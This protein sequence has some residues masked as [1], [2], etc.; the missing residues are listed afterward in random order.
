[1]QHEGFTVWFTGMSGAGKSTLARLLAKKLS[2]VHARVEVLDGD[3]VRQTLCKDLDYGEQDRN[4]NVRRIGFVCELLSRNNVIAIVAAI[5]PYRTARAEVRSR[6]SRFVEVYVECPLSVLVQRDPKGLYQR[7]IRGE[8][9]NF[10][11]ISAPYEPPLMPELTV[12]SD[13]ETPESA[14]DKIWHEIIR[15]GLISCNQ[16]ALKYERIQPIEPRVAGVDACIPSVKWS[17]R[18]VPT[19]GSVWTN[20]K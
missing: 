11:G 9:T 16:P 1:M 4:E 5:S 7:A 2:V 8:I 13:R 17:A 6:I 3:V 10:T 20:S 14:V 15:A 18:P 19:S 12:R